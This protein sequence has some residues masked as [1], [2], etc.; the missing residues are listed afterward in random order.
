MFLN[1]GMLTSVSALLVL[2][3]A[4]GAQAASWGY[5]GDIGPASWHE[6]SAEYER[7]G[8]GRNQSPV[9]L[10]GMV[11]A[12]LEPVAFDYTGRAQSLVNN[13]HTVKATVASGGSLSVDDRNYELKQFHFHAPSENRI[14]GESFPMEAHFV[15]ADADGHLAVVAVLFREGEEN[16]ALDDLWEEIPEEEGEPRELASN[17]AVM[18]ADLLPSQR[19]YYRYNGSLTTPPCSEGVLWMVMEEPVTVS[20]DQ[21]EAFRDA[22]DGHAN[23]R[24]VQ[25]LNARAILK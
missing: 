11:D 2:A 1:K 20:A 25:P 4:S 24:P 8:N 6:L 7:C 18:P 9:D 19:T 10:R 16:D 14:R 13:G 17:S 23:N 5:Q 15:H 21:V 12:A 22:M 3:S